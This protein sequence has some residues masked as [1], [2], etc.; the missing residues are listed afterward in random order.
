MLTSAALDDYRARLLGMRSRLIR[1]VTDI[2]SEIPH[3]V[4][5]P[6]E[7]TT[8]PLHPA[9]AAAEEL[10]PN[11]ALAQNEAG[12]LEEVEAALERIEQG[13]FGRC[14]SCGEEISPERLDAIPY[15]PYCVTC[16]AEA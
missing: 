15:T 12:L 9:D 11:L 8:V 7:I 3:D 4:V 6:G 14:D 2:E 10:D 5:A 1:E 13:T 16:A